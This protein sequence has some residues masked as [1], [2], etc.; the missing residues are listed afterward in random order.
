MKITNFRRF[1]TLF[2]LFFI[3]FTGP[4][5]PVQVK[6]L[7]DNTEKNFKDG[8]PNDV[9]ISSKGRLSLAFQTQTLLEENEDV[10][11][12]NAVVRGSD[13]NLYAAASAKGKGLIYRQADGREPVAIYGEAENEQQHVFSL[14]LD[15]QGR[16]LAGTGGTAGQLLRFDKNG[17]YKVLFE[18]QELHY[19][20]SIAVAP[21]GMIYLGTGPQGKVIKLDANGGEPDVLY[22]AKEKNIL[23][24][25]IDDTGRLYA[26]GDKHGL[27]YRIDPGSKKTVVAYD[28]GHAE[29]SGL[30]FDEKGNLYVATSDAGGAKPGTQLILSDGDTSRPETDADSSSENNTRQPD[31]DEAE[32]ETKSDDANEESEAADDSDKLVPAATTSSNT[33]SN[34]SGGAA[35]GRISV[36]PA[37]AN[38]VFQIS[39]RGFVQSLFKQNVMIMAMVYTGEGKLALGTSNDGQII[40]L[41]VVTQDAVIL[42]E[43][44]GSRQITALW[45]DKNGVLV[46]GGANA[47]QLLAV[48]PDYVREGFFDSRVLDADQVSRWGGLQVAAMV[49]EGTGLTLQTRTGNTDDPEKGGWQPWTDPVEVREEQ[50]VI[51]EAGRFLQYRFTLLSQDGAKTPQ[52]SEVKV[53]H[54]I[55]N[56]PPHL[57]NVTVTQNPDKKRK[58]E[59]VGHVELSKTMTIKWE[60]KDDNDDQLLFDVYLRPLEHQRWVRVAKNLDK[61]EYQWNSLTA[62]DDRY[63]FKVRASDR[64]N[65]PPALALDVARIS[66]P[67]IVDNTPP[68]IDS[69][70]QAVNGKTCRFTLG[71]TDA[72]STLAWVDYLVNSGEEWQAILPED[73]I[74]D[75]RWERFRFEV[76]LQEDG[77]HNVTL[78]IED[79]LGNL[80]YRNVRVQVP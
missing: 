28:T 72:M 11:V 50:D 35:A 38:E 24:V 47:G 25:A 44:R 65:N 79:S 54:L 33:P 40:S 5:W 10:W 3:I 51:S 2:M 29:I 1:F 20:W 16:L 59:G 32:S 53:A 67:V 77:E 52:V 75:N 76:D 78:R 60:A 4:A 13:S 15:G 58:A 37:G 26:G 23:S 57:A 48:R 62:A 31:S 69:L 55:P 45:R 63:E 17:K 7:S 14:A 41:D 19:I 12:I 49:P 43:E 6:Y 18:E 70:N 21:D 36:S 46:A 8:D 9:V 61:P 68:T 71:I 73:G 30:V 39:P 34:E 64:K 74:Y 22:N 27:V 42:H 80:M 66:E 56:L